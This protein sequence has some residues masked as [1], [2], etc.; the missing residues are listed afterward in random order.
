[1][2]RESGRVTFSSLYNNLEFS[3]EKRQYLGRLYEVLFSVPAVLRDEFQSTGEIPTAS[4]VADHFGISKEA[5]LLLLEVL[6]SDSRVPELYTRDAGTGEITSLNLELIEAFIQHRGGK[7]KITRWEGT[8]VP[9][10]QVRTLD[11]ELLTKD[12]LLGRNYLI[13]FWF[14]GCPPCVKIAPILADL[15]KDYRS[16][17]IEFY[18]LN[19]DDLLELG[20]T[21]ESRRSYLY[22][23]GIHFLNANLDSSTR[24]AFGNVNV[25]PTLFFV[26]KHGIIVRHLVNFQS[27]ETLVEVLEQMKATS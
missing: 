27:R 1:M 10:F 12:Q 9:D 5:M 4:K 19:A 21:N 3:S 11:G 13:Y 15:A 7:V 23:Q 6:E 16:S 8:S 25:Y 14:T 17:E 20:T 26:D 2:L 18:G 22:K 24:E